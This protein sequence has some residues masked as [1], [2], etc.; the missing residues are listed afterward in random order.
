[1]SIFQSIQSTPLL[2]LL[3]GAASKKRPPIQLHAFASSL[4]LSL[5]WLH[6]S[7][8]LCSQNL[9]GYTASNIIPFMMSPPFWDHCLPSM[10]SSHSQIWWSYTVSWCSAVCHLISTAEALHVTEEKCKKKKTETGQRK[11]CEAM[12]ES[13]NNISEQQNWKKWLFSQ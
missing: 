8:S 2:W 11:L 9:I 3:L 13:Q 4:S 12:A 1:M 10:T 5:E 7:S 6:L